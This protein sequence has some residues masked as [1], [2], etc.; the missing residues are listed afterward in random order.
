MGIIVSVFNCFSSRVTGFTHIWQ[1]ITP[2][3]Y[4]VV[5]LSFPFIRVT[6][7]SLIQKLK[8]LFSDYITHHVGSED[9]EVYFH[10]SQYAKARD[11][12]TTIEN[13]GMLALGQF[14]TVEE[15]RRLSL[16]YPGCNLAIVKNTLYLKN[17]E[18]M[19][20]DAGVIDDR[21]MVHFDQMWKAIQVN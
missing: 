6:T 21:A 15:M 10:N 5:E 12:K 9:L 16:T 1:E 3:K 14:E 13:S 4:A 17:P 11:P 20:T 2:A 18:K 7:M 19:W 8:H